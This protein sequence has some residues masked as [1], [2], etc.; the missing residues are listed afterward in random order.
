MKTKTIVSQS[1]LKICSVVHMQHVYTGAWPRSLGFNILKAWTWETE[2]LLLANNKGGTAWAGVVW[3]APLLFPIWKLN[4]EGQIYLSSRIILV[5]FNMIKPLA[6]Q[7]LW[8]G[9]HCGVFAKIQIAQKMSY[10]TVCVSRLPNPLMLNCWLTM[11]NNCPR[12]RI[13]NQGM[14]CNSL[15]VPMFVV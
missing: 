3:S 12:K 10:V 13:K 2:T 6:M 4:L 1:T 11:K 14:S 9:L 15:W 5:G 7:L 8:M